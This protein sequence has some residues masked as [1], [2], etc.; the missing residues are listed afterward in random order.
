MASISTS[1][2]RNTAIFPER[3]SQWKLK[4]PFPHIRILKKP[5]QIK[6]FIFVTLANILHYFLLLAPEQL[7]S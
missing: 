5:P 3:L 1:G 2:N 4:V 7:Y 6:M